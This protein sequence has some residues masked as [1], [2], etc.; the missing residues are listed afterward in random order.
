M[1][2]LGHVRIF[3]A[4]YVISILY[5]KIEKSNGIIL[6]AHIR[7]D[8]KGSH[9]TLLKMFSASV[10]LAVAFIS[11]D[12]YIYL[13]A[14]PHSSGSRG[15]CLEYVLNMKRHWKARGYAGHRTEN[16]VR[17]AAMCL[18]A[19]RDRGKHCSPNDSFELLKTAFSP[20]RRGAR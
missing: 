4:R 12:I 8:S 11:A 7:K 20:A 16:P 5:H 19:I 9:S 10:S 1:Q 17:R 6:G 2:K 18:P 15:G 14:V 3:A 13:L